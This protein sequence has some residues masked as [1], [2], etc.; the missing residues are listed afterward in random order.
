LNAVR[1]EF[2]VSFAAA[3]L[4]FGVLDRFKL[5]GVIATWWTDTLAD[6]KT[7]TENGF[8]GVID[9]WIDGIAD[10]LEDDDATGPAFDP[11]GHKL[12]RST[13][14]DYLDRVSTA[15]SEIA[16]LKA[17]KESFEKSNS[18]DDADDEELVGWNYAK[19]LERRARELRAENR[20]ALNE[21]GKL[22][23]TAARSRATDSDRRASAD[24]KARL[25]PIVDQLSGLE[26]DLEPYE[27]TKKLLSES[28][29][30]YRELSNKFVHELRSRSLSLR[31]DEKRDLVLKLVAQDAETGL[32]AAWREEQAKLIR[33]I[34]NL[35]DK[36]QVTLER[37]QDDRGKLEHQV[38]GLISTLGYQ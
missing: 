24:A 35:W 32:D 23:K 22:E 12:V 31:A 8:A 38:D 3:L 13:M 19:D 26:A 14:G 7:L 17:E 16:R 11:L 18:P 33:G 15:K 20:H 1:A 9:G 25:Q 10:A 36:Y 30:D 34:E 28:R 6:L 21:L 5:A 27:Q 37:L 4:P 29:S 2:L